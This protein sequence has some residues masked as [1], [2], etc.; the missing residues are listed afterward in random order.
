MKIAES[1]TSSR[2]TQ[3][4]PHF[5]FLAF[6]TFCNYWPY[7]YPVITYYRRVC[8]PFNINNIIFFFET[9]FFYFVQFSE[10]PI[11]LCSGHAAHYHPVCESDTHLY[12]KAYNT[13]VRV[14]K[15]FYEFE[16]ILFLLQTYGIPD[17][18][19]FKPLS[20]FFCHANAKTDEELNANI[21]S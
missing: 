12:K 1:F 18:V 13:T 7:P 3:V 21:C 16:K 8:V 17:S 19:L 10:R 11:E 15:S 4:W 20:C 6:S 5:L 14:H 9:H 2:G